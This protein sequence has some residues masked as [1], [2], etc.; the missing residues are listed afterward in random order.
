MAVSSHAG[1]EYRQRSLH[2]ERHLIRQIMLVDFFW[3]RDEDSRDRLEH[4]SIIAQ[5]RRGHDV[6]AVMTAVSDENLDSAHAT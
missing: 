5:L 3:A 1:P 2:S 6:R 4:T